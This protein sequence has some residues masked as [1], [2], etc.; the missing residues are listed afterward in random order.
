[1]NPIKDIKIIKISSKGQMATP[2]EFRRRL[3]LASG[4]QLVI[5]LNDE[6]QM[7]LQKLP[8]SLDWQELTADIPVEQVNIDQDGYYDV[9]KT[10]SFDE[11]M[12]EE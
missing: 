1:M 5:T 6:G 4:T 7:V 12:H 3:N 2:L 8:S 10:P 9:K 11:W